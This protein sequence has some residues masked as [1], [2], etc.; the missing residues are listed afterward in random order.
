[1]EHLPPGALLLVCPGGVDRTRALY[2]MEEASGRQRPPS[3]RAAPEHVFAIE[4]QSTPTT[5]FMSL[6]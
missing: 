2:S 6:H 3:S 5:H 4:P 1:M